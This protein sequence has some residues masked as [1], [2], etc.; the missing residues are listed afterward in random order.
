MGLFDQ[1]L[2]A[3][4]SSLSGQSSGGQQA[5]LGVVVRLIN[6]PQTGGLAGLVQK[7]RD[8]GLGA[9]VDS[10]VSNGAKLPVTPAQIQAVLGNEQVQHLASL[11]GM[12]AT[13]VTA[14]LAQHLPQII[15]DLTPNGH[16]TEGDLMA[17]GMDLLKGK[18]FG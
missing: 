16:V 14:Q 6:N 13:Q 4:A 7:F 11:L 18:L 5:L 3:A 9:V 12:D 8:E 17:Q 10:W 1:V 2:G 15:D